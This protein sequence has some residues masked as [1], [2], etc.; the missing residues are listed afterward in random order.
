MEKQHEIFTPF[1][2]KLKSSGLFPLT[3]C[4]VGILQ[5]NLGKKCNQACKHCHVAAGPTRTELM[6]DETLERCLDILQ[7]SGISAVDITGGAPELHP[8]YRELVKRCRS[9]GKT[10]MTRC[11]LTV[12]LEEGCTDMAEFFREQS[13]VVMASLPYYKKRETDAVR[14]AGVFDKSIEAIRMLNEAGFG[15]EGSGLILN[16]VYNP[17]GA[18]L[19]PPQPELENDFK[20]ELEKRHSLVFNNLLTMI[21]MPIARFQEYLERTKNYLPYVNRLVNSFNPDA[22]ANVMCRSLLSVGWDGSMYDCDFNQML[23]ITVNHGAPS[24]VSDWDL[25]K[26]SGRQIMTGIHCYGCTAGSGSSCGGSIS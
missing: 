20:R 2:E 14:G 9:L 10:V 11:N 8:R 6:D 7:K 26:L 18:F 3:A 24:H 17:A 25:G 13:V 12:L 22:A 1:D 4:S 16:L 5:L 15:V 23:D 19:P 21:N